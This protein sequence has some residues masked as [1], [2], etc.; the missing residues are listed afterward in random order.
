MHP[1][2]EFLKPASYPLP[3]RQIGEMEKKTS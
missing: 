1:R 2:R 3:D